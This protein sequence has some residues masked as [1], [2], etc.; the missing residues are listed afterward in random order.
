MLNDFIFVH[1]FTEMLSVLFS[2]KTSLK[3]KVGK[4]DIDYKLI[5]RNHNSRRR[6]TERST[7]HALAATSGERRAAGAARH[8]PG[9]HP[10][11]DAKPQGHPYHP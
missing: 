9:S 11:P 5:L 2:F 7:Q 8:E 1:D 6:Y 3:V 10:A 4:I